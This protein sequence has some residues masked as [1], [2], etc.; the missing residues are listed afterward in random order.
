[1]RIAL[2]AMGGDLAPAAPVEGAVRALGAFPDVE[3]VLVGLPD[4]IEEELARHGGTDRERLTVR[5]GDH[6]AAMGE[7]P[8]KA[9]RTHPGNTARIGAELLREGEV[10]GVVSMGST[11]AAV[12][13]AQ[14]YCGR[15]EGVK[16]PGIAAPFPRAD[17]ITLVVDA[18]AN[19][20]VR[21]EHLYQ[22]AV[23]ASLYASSALDVAVPRIG[24]LSIGEE[25]HKG[26]SLVHQTWDLFEERG[27]GNFVGNVEPGDLF[28][29]VADVVVSDGFTG[30]VALKTAEGM[31]EFLL[32]EVPP[33]LP[34]EIDAQAFVTRLASR[35]DYA[36]YGGAPLLGI[37][38][39]YLIGHG[40]S[41]ARAVLNAIR[42]VRACIR[43]HVGEQIVAA[44]ASVKAAFYSPGND[45]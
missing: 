27:L 24:I 33:I 22:F 4:R 26:T 16:R 15:L 35:V 45:G 6:V 36:E 44:L 10:S 11:G 5:A 19:P 30:N 41:N 9:V 40:R 13:A 2:D 18:G 1:M 37:R 17:G 12:A 43:H 3:L 32:G 29:D 42:A 8:V 21:P 31:A 28:R 38:G 14:L 34:P 39:A 23:M 20:E 7:D 25:R